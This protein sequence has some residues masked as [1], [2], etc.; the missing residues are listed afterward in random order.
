MKPKNYTAFVSFSIAVYD[1]L[2]DRGW[3]RLERCDAPLDGAGKTLVESFPLSAWRSLRIKALGSKRKTKAAD[4]TA[5]LEDLR[6]VFPLL[7]T[8]EPSHDE[9]QAL[10]SGLA[11]IAMERGASEA[12]VTSGVAP[13]RHEGI[14]REGFIVNPVRL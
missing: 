3:T 9:L 12:C 7:V 8:E 6:T 10:V 2:V 11:G 13:F 4:I 1:A 14:V 5:R